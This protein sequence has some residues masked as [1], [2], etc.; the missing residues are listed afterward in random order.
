VFPKKIQKDIEQCLEIA[1]D[2]YLIK[3]LD[4]KSIEIVF[5]I[6]PKDNTSYF[7]SFEHLIFNCPKVID[8]L[9]K[10]ELV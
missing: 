6:C 10:K 1:Y 4:N 7:F 3:L 8:Y 5:L 9:E 2:F